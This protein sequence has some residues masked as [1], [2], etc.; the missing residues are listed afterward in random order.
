MRVWS[1]VFLYAALIFSFSSLPGQYVPC[2]FPQ[3][4]KIYHF[5]EY[6]PFGILVARAFAST[7]KFKTVDCFMVSLFVIVLYA[8]SD[9][10]HQLFVPARV[11]DVFDMFSDAAGAAFGSIIYLRW[12]R[13]NLS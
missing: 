12:R 13:S 9:E 3:A 6:L 7:G 8:F 4:D 2:L 11:F 1:P 10:F 5:S